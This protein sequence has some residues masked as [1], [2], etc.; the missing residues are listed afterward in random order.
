MGQ[1]MRLKF[2]LAPAHL[3]YYSHRRSLAGNEFG[4]VRRVVDLMV[5]VG[6]VVKRL[7]KN[8]F[9]VC[10]R[11]KSRK[12]LLPL[13]VLDF[14]KNGFSGVLLP[15]SEPNKKGLVGVLP[16]LMLP[17]CRKKLP[18]LPLLPLVGSLTG[19]KVLPTAKGLT[20][21]LCCRLILLK[22]LIQSPTKRVGQENIIFIIFWGIYVGAA[23]PNRLLGR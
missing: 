20:V 7:S 15:L 6:V 5:G 12:L 17:V 4:L 8:R 16:P 2:G 18:P 23:V 9:V 11:L 19:T 14:G 13:F 22:T 10:W 21:R 1:S 3:G